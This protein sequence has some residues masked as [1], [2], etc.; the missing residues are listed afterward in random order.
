MLYKVKGWVLEDYTDYDPLT[1][2]V[3]ILKIPVTKTYYIKAETFNKA[4]AK[5]EKIFNQ[6]NEMEK[7]S[8]E[9]MDV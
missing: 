3:E 2:K 7:V 8:G 5:S 1:G 6:I 4:F 9:F